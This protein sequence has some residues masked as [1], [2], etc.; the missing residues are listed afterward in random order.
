VI[1]TAR[2]PDSAGLALDGDPQGVFPAD[3]DD[4]ARIAPYLRNTNRRQPQMLA[5][6]IGFEMA[7]ALRTNGLRVRIVS[8]NRT[9][10]AGTMRRSPR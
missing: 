5:R 9:C 8:A 10:S 4:A 3:L 2:V 7:E 6:Y 1:A